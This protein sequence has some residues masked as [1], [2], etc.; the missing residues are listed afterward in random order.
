VEK[1]KNENQQ[2]RICYGMKKKYD[3]ETDR[4]TSFPAARN[5]E[6]RKTGEKMIKSEKTRYRYY[7]E[8]PGSIQDLILN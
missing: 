3:G 7:R 8:L 6:V 2:T 5:Q 4:T 1:S